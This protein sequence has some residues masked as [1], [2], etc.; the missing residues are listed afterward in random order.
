MKYLDVYLSDLY[1]GQA[2]YDRGV[3]SYTYASE[4]VKETGKPISVRM[5]LQSESFSQE[6]ARPFFAN[7]LPEGR[8]R[9]LFARAA[10][11]SEANDYQFL[12]KAGA[13]CAG[14]LGLYIPGLYK[15]H[16]P[17]Y[18]KLTAEQLDK[19]YF[20]QTNN[21][22]LVQYRELRLSL[23]G[24]QD[25]VPI[26]IKN[27]E[28][29]LPAGNAPSSHIFKPE[30]PAFP[31]LVFNEAFCADLGRAI[32]LNIPS[33]KISE[34]AG[35]YG[36]IMQRYDR[37][38]NSSGAVKRIHQE[39]FCQALSVMPEQK[40]QAEGG[41]SVKDCFSVLDKY[42]LFALADRQRLLELICFNYCIGNADAHS[43]NLSLLHSADGIILAPFYD[44][45]STMAYDS[46]STK[47][48]MK[49]G[50][51]YRLTHIRRSHWEKLA[52]ETGLKPAF[53]LDML[54]DIQKRCL[55]HLN[56]IQANYA[57]YNSAELAQVIEIIRK[58]C[59]L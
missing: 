36:Y 18:T 4:Y 52:Q 30:N 5:P 19:L 2:G 53:V 42:S 20:S 46:L 26:Y 10:K 31:G 55:K 1:S 28:F 35:K 7:L 29:Y 11:I 24:A 22:L 58:R 3:Y 56:S 6:I 25:K 54:N 17:V 14:A 32:G 27:N 15:K 39:D 51:E 45:V 47:A 23:A 13:E 48:A 37:E 34:H 38:I 44:L 16:Q 43:K 40:Y 49:T 21:P 33:V 12:E 41:P 50:G 8:I 57:K 59:S 9:Q